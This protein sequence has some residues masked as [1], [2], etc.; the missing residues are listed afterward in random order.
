MIFENTTS[1]TNVNKENITCIT[2]I[3]NKFFQ[4]QNEM[5]KIF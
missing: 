2:C 5:K 1:E 3:V 4:L